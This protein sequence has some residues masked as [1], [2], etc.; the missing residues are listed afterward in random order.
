MRCSIKRLYH[1]FR[2]IT[3]RCGCNSKKNT[4]HNDL[5]DLKWNVMPQ[6]HI[7]DRYLKTLESFEVKNDGSGLDY[8][9]SNKE[10]T[11]KNDIPASHLAGYI[12][13]VIGAAHN[14]KKYPVHKLKY[15]CA[16]LDH[17]IILLG[18]KQDK[19]GGDEIASVDPV[20]I[21]N[22]CGKFSI[23]ESADLVRK[24]KLIVT[25]D[26]GLMHVAAAFKKPLISLWGNTVPSFGMYPYYGDSY[27]QSFRNSNAESR[28]PFDILQVN[29]LSC[30]P[31]SKIG[32]DKCPKKHFKCM[33]NIEISEVLKSIHSRL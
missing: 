22:A 6:L 17:P 16:Q 14:T 15:L 18:G 10:E 9:I 30:R 24:S 5:Q 3:Q 7:V 20:K 27:L 11:K 28:T 32:Y 4:E 31:C 33:E 21:Y 1:R 8:F 26:T 12:G 29:K 2:V 13:I 23:N 25:N 19:K